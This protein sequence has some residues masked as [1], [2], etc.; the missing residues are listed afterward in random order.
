MIINPT[1]MNWDAEGRLWVA[2]TPDYPQIK[3]GHMA[4]DQIVVLEDIDK[5]GKADKHHVFV[6]NVLIPTAVIMEMAAFTWPTLL[7]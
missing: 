5:D 1:N 7:S 4:S 6:D 2:C 3:P